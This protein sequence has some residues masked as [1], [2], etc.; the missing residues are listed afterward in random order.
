MSS[1]DE[2]PEEELWERSLSEDEVDRA[3]SLMELAHRARNRDDFLVAK[4]L[5]GS[6]LDLFEELGRET[7]AAMA[8]Y[9]FGFCQYR[10]GEYEEAIASLAKSLER[11]RELNDSRTIAY[12]AGPLGDSQSA[13]G[14]RPEAIE[15]YDLAVDAYVEIEEYTSAGFNAMSLGELH[16]LEGRQTRALECFIR[17]FNVFQSGGDGYGAARAKDRMASALIELGDFDQALMHI[18]DALQVFTFLDNDERV[19]H[20]NYRLG[21]TL[22]LA[23]KYLQAEEP[24][25]LS[26]KVFRENNDFSRAGLAEVQLAYSLIFRDLEADHTIAQ[27]LLDRA[28]AYFDAAGEQVNVL[29]AQSISAERLML[30]GSFLAATELWR[31]ILYRAISYEDDYSARSA[32]ASLAECLFQLGQNT[33]AKEVFSEINPAD[34]GEN[35]PELDRIERIKKLMLDK[36][37][38]TLNIEL[39]R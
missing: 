13:L 21:W 10:L 27:G 33:E 11:G 36:M 6:A 24:L 29:V 14:N 26:I 15:A 35:K 39:P 12:S 23:G 5:Y 38:E 37:A 8:N 31:D 25:R 7:D 34:W 30:E 22:N 2:M 18:K 9:S 32:K 3:D 1:H 20:M 28:A 19:A 4:N 16:G 17:A